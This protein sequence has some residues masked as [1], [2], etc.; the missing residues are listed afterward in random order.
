[1]CRAQ[2]ELLTQKIGHDLNVA[3]RFMRDAGEVSFSEKTVHWEAVN[4][5]TK[6][7][8]RVDLPQMLVGDTW[9]GQNHDPAAVSPVVDAVKDLVGGTCTIFQRMNDAGDMLRVS[10]NVA[11]L[12][13]KRAIGTYIPASSA[14]GAPNQV[15]SAVLQ[16]QTF[17]GRAFVVNA[18]Y[19]TAYEPIRD[20]SGEVA[21]MLYVGVKEE[22]TDSLRQAIMSVKV[23]QTG[24]VYVLNARGKSRGHYVISKGGQRDGEDLWEAQDADGNL[25]IQDLCKQAVAL[26]P[27]EIGEIR[28]FWQNA[29]EAEAREKVVK[30]AYFAPWDWVIGT[31]AYVD[32]LYGVVRD[33][34]AQADETLTAMGT[35]QASSTKAV[36]VWCVGIAIAAVVVS[37]IVAWWVTSGIARPLNRAIDGLTEGADQVNEA[38]SQVAAASQQLAEGS[39][40][41]ASS[42]EETSAALEEMAS[43]TRTN[44]DRARQANELSEQARTAA[45]QSD[46]TM[47]RLNRAMVGIEESSGQISKIIKVIEEIAFQTNLLALNAAVEAARAGEHGKGF[48]VVADEVRNLAQRAAQAAKETTT[49]IEESV[50]RSQEGSQ[51]A[52]EVGEALSTIAGNVTQVS[53]LINGIAKASEE[54]AQGVDQVNAA[55]TDMNRITQ[56]NASGAE[57]S[58]SASEELSAQARNVLSMVDALVA[59]VGRGGSAR[60]RTEAGTGTA[61]QPHP[62]G[63]TRSAGLARNRG[64]A[65]ENAASGPTDAADESLSF[66]SAEQEVHRF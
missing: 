18:W 57:E 54:Q 60:G 31:G 65:W 9:L 44:A 36:L 48:A 41:Q 6:V 2:Q 64:A 35:T 11:K 17:R 21:G 5:E 4:Q 32:E 30:L 62:P 43:T 55:V 39:S 53:D 23:G 59:T 40:E 45:R 61:D 58:A 3:R 66:D 7:G 46:Q 22:S 42:L 1:M 16:G 19:I 33:M 47:E 52:G 34:E 14:D 20:A 50:G 38:A 51:V 25:F 28:Y 63:P 27:G 10:T 12:D 29:G 26:G 13:G 15:V 24:Y 8:R 56:Q 49:L 37:L